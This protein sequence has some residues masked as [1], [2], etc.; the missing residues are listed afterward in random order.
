MLNILKNKKLDRNPLSSRSPTKRV[1]FS[2]S[3]FGFR[4][5]LLLSSCAR[6]K[7]SRRPR[8]KDVNIPFP[9]R[10]KRRNNT[11]IIL[12]LLFRYFAAVVVPLIKRALFVRMCAV[13]LKL[14]NNNNIIIIKLYSPPRT[15]F[16]L[17]IVCSGGRKL[18]LSAT[19]TH[20]EPFCPP[21]S[22]YRGTSRALYM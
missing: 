8:T 3:F 12:L 20:D 9:S 22:F 4:S 14:H 11:T 21:P 19:I 13:S 2:Y 10:T 17:C 15:R 1:F 18:S 6:H 7:S 5:K 16:V